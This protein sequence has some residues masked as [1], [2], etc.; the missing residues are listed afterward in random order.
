MS[1]VT[2]FEEFCVWSGV[3]AW[4]LSSTIGNILFGPIDAFM[5]IIATCIFTVI[6]GVLYVDYKTEGQGSE[7]KEREEYHFF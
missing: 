5:S 6:L 1:D 3:W 7:T 4:A 2:K